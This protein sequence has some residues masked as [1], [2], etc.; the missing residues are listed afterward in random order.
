MTQVCG[1]L[2]RE[3]SGS[4]RALLWLAPFT[5]QGAC[6]PVLTWG[7]VDGFPG[8]VGARKSDHDAAPASNVPSVTVK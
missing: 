4:T 5:L 7:S 6:S 1:A 8:L 3:D 2:A